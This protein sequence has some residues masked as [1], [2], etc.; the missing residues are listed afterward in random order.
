MSLFFYASRFHV[1]DHITFSFHSLLYFHKSGIISR[2]LIILNI[3]R[4]SDFMSILQLML[5][6]TAQLWIVW[7][8]A[9]TQSGVMSCDCCWLLHS[10]LVE[11]LQWFYN[12]LDAHAILIVA[13]PSCMPRKQFIWHFCHVLFTLSNR[14]TSCYAL[15]QNWLPSS[16]PPMQFMPHVQ[17][18]IQQ[19][20]VFL[21][22]T[23]NIQ[24]D[25]FDPYIGS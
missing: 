24:T 8:K 11:N 15:P 6:S 19:L 20:Q 1:Q 9:S 23:N 18:N 4:F 3:T 21:S 25:L 13:L 22:N 14:C 12:F 10:P 2:H 17:V 16:M 7:H 5:F